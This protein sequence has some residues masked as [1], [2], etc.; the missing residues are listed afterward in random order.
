MS[1]VHPT[2]DA[3]MVAPGLPEGRPPVEG[4]TGG[5]ADIQAA[6]PGTDHDAGSSSTLSGNIEGA[7][8]AAVARLANLQSETLQQ[9]STIGDTMTLPPSPIQ[10]ETILGYIAEPHNIGGLGKG[11]AS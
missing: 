1:N 6:P 7:V 10:D 3:S 5:A 11:L 2:P 9:G 8:A 4:P